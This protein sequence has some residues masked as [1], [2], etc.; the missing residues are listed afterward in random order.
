MLMEGAGRG[1]WQE[2]CAPQAPSLGPCF[3]SVSGFFS[4]CLCLTLTSLS[5]LLSTTPPN[6]Q[7]PELR[8]PTRTLTKEVEFEK[9]TA[10]EPWGCPI[11]GITP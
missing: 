10:S 5:C 11:S 4:V 6:P 1:G 7:T 3:S 2:G 8:A 9:I